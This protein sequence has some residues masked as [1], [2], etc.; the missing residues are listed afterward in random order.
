MSVYYLVLQTCYSFENE[1]L[2]FVILGRIMMTNWKV[3][4]IRV[5]QPAYTYQFSD[6]LIDD[7]LSTYT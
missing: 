4:V 5:D 2:F 7:C 3:K 6:F 1:S